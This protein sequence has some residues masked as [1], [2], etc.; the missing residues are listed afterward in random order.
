MNKTKKIQF[1]TVRQ[2]LH[3]NVQDIYGQ[4]C[5]NPT[6]KYPPSKKTKQ[7]TIVNI[8]KVDKIVIMEITHN[9]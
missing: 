2:N 6:S 9:C 4:D 8:N 5:Y 1:I 7:N 3:A